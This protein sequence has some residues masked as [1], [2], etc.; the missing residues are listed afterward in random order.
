M[1]RDMVT[2]DL[3]KI[4]PVIEAKRTAYS[5]SNLEKNLITTRFQLSL[6]KRSV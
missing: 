4:N 3:D 1:S 5:L 6:K 2:L